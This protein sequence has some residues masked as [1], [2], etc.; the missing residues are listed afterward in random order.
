MVKM[1]A[2]HSIGAK[3]TRSMAIRY[4]LRMTSSF[5]PPLKSPFDLGTSS[6]SRLKNVCVSGAMTHDPMMAKLRHFLPLKLPRSVSRVRGVDGFS[7]VPLV[8]EPSG[9]AS[10]F[11]IEPELSLEEESD[12]LFSRLLNCINYKRGVYASLFIIK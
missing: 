8:C 12:D 4:K 10:R 9:E 5:T 2:K 3:T 1:L 7:S 6:S 11:S